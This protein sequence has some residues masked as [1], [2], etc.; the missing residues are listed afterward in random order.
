MTPPIQTNADPSSSR[1]CP[2]PKPSSLSLRTPGS[3]SV[4]QL[5]SRWETQPETSPSPPAPSA[6]APHIASLIRS[7]LS[8]QQNCSQP[9][10]V[11]CA[12]LPNPLDATNG[13]LGPLD[14]APKYG[15]PSARVRTSP[16]RLATKSLDTALQP[17]QQAPNP[18]SNRYQASPGTQTSPYSFNT[19][20]H[21]VPLRS[22]QPAQ[23]IPSPV[24][25]SYDSVRSFALDLPPPSPST[26]SPLTEH[27]QSTPQSTVD[28]I[29]S[30]TRILL[31]NATRSSTV[32]A[33]LQSAFA[34]PLNTLQSQPAS[35][36]SNNGRA[37]WLLSA[38]AQ[39]PTPSSTDRSASSEVSPRSSTP[40]SEPD[41][42]KFRHD[43]RPHLE[44]PLPKEGLSKSSSNGHIFDLDAKVHLG[45]GKYLPSSFRRNRP[46]QAA[47]IPERS[48]S[49]LLASSSNA[50]I[51]S[52]REAWSAE[53]PSSIPL[54]PTSPIKEMKARS[55]LVGAQA[56]MWTDM[57]KNEIIQNAVCSNVEG[58]MLPVSADDV[59]RRDAAPIHL[60]ALENYLKNSIMF[61]EPNFTDSRLVCTEQEKQLFD[62]DGHMMLGAPIDAAQT[63]QLP[64]SSAN[65]SQITK[66]RI[67][68]LRMSSHF[69]QLEV[70]GGQINC[71][72]LLYIS[73]INS[74][75][76]SEK[77]KSGLRRR[78]GVGPSNETADLPKRSHTK[79]SKGVMKVNSEDADPLLA[80]RL[81]DSS[82]KQL[83]ID[84]D[85]A[86]DAT[87]IDAKEE[88]GFNSDDDANL[89]RR[90]AVEAHKVASRISARLNDSKQAG[91]RSNLSEPPAEGASSKFSTHSNPV[92]RKE[93]FPP[94]MLLKE[95]NLDELKSNAI[96]P[97]KPPGGIWAFGWLGFIFDMVI[98]VEGSTFAAGILRLE[99]LRDLFQLMT[100][101][102]HFQQYFDSS[103]PTSTTS[104]VFKFLL[105]TLPAILGFDLVS[106]FGYAIIFFVIWIVITA[107]ALWHFRRMTKAHNPN[108]TVEGFDSQGWI[109]KSSS[110][111][112][113]FANTC[114]VFVL[115]LLYLPLSKLAVDVLVWSS[116]F[117]PVPD[118]YK[119]GIDDPIPGPLLGDPDIWRAPLD[120]CYTTT[121]RKDAFNWAY[122]II[123][124]AVLT[125][126]FY[127]LWYPYKLMMTIKEMLPRVSPFNELGRKRSEEEMQICYHRLLNRDKS[128]FNF[129][130]N[131]YHR[132]WGYYKPLYILLFKLTNLL[133]IGVLAKDNCFF[134]S[135]RTRTMLVVQ[136]STLIVVMSSLLAVHLT[137]QPFVDKN[138]NRSELVSRIGYV[139]TATIGLLVALNVQGSTVYN[140]TI[141]YIVQAFT[142][143]GNIYFG[144]IG[145]SF[146][147]HQIKR[148][149]KRVD[150]TIDIFSPVLDITKHIKRRVWEETFS[151]LILC[152]RE[153]H[154]PLEQVIAF[155]VSDGD[156]WPPYLIGFQGSVAER[157]IENLKIVKQIGIEAYRSEI[158]FS[159]TQ[160]GAYRQKLI[161]TIQRDLT[162]PDAY[163]RPQ[164]PP[165]PSGA[166][167]FFGKAFLVPFPPTLVIRYDEGTTNSITLTR[168]EEFEA[169]IQQNSEPKVVSQRMVRQAL[170]ALEGQT[171]FCPH[172][173][174][175]QVGD[176]TSGMA[177]VDKIFGRVSK[178]HDALPRFGVRT[179]AGRQSEY[180]L[181]TPISY[182]QGTLK[183]VRR[184]ELDW[185]GYNLDS[186]FEVSI[187][188]KEG[189]MKETT[190]ALTTVQKTVEVSAS[191]AFG[192]TDNFDMTSTLSRFLQD[193]ETLILERVPLIEKF[194][195]KYRRD[196]EREARHKERVLPYSFLSDV[197]DNDGL[198]PLG[199]RMALVEIG[200]G[201]S[202][203]NLPVLYEGCVTLMYERL[204]AIN[205]SPVHR[206]WWILFDEIWRLNSNDYAL[207][208]KYRRSFSPQYPTSIAYRP[209]PRKAL[210]E[211]LTERGLWKS[212]GAKGGP[213]NRGLLNRIYFYLNEIVFAGHHDGRVSD[214]GRAQPNKGRVSHPHDSTDPF[215]DPV[216][217]DLRQAATIKVGLGHDATQATR[218]DFS[219]VDDSMSKSHLF[220]PDNGTSGHREKRCWGMTASSSVTPSQ[221]T[222]GGTAYSNDSVI[223]RTAYRWEQ[224]MDG[225]ATDTS[226]QRFKVRSLQWLSLHPVEVNFKREK[227]YL[228]LKL[229]KDKNGQERYELLKPSC[230]LPVPGKQEI[231]E[232][233]ER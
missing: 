138:G 157:H 97:R 148:W 229:A 43:S 92:T 48:S 154:M 210:E 133:I 13:T 136:Q 203:R 15:M 225:F 117:W 40:R 185:A 110:R 31:E 35:H 156:E 25:P 106:V 213:F 232:R 220:L 82:E 182:V 63:P 202:L 187:V 102:L 112:T 100:L 19:K 36:Q 196:F 217:S 4:Q 34:S 155:S 230:S 231:G 30:K 7:P 149:Q 179:S 77:H 151:I 33:A 51:S 22:V 1:T 94:L 218:Q 90:D 86:D 121:M 153:Y 37:S 80:R 9:A 142:Y 222:G 18:F 228:Y 10:P 206:F 181:A 195:R 199:L 64:T 174:N 120:F 12:L 103:D 55:S 39:E 111:G 38:T 85:V 161:R 233:R 188:Y 45:T 71:P 165:F 128:P 171:V 124:M 186:G 215:L 200:C 72:A 127:T 204:A 172:V 101:Q 41:T 175:I 176:A 66:S 177:V 169:Y 224:M 122:I 44:P 214:A 226:W 69:G 114:L 68:K 26:F 209:I 223:V 164:E 129:L 135:F 65:R 116:D 150:Y 170:R 99:T 147:A 125:I 67:S 166:T 11:H 32:S 163:W 140:T 190:G 115:G 160:Q 192:L 73:S 59:F 2:E 62:L 61:G 29:A 159:R 198:S 56:I 5:V 119:G 143:G 6:S 145:M 123:P 137:I 227:L 132:S 27:T 98:G 58:D 70:A 81:I 221:Y 21:L 146:V 74:D 95:N 87:A 134:R 168:I 17:S 208:T 105:Q 3:P 183:I 54:L 96:G 207:L 189:K 42:D 178:R 79:K 52:A 158:D 144:L 173:E 201:R 197:F 60:P 75:H 24:S 167:S 83:S 216:D 23:T 118:P 53:D 131:S 84:D 93:M 76:N 50:D 219:T 211:F 57:V 191:R 141:L 28:T 139:L 47:P 205:R 180:V 91:A 46:E 184:N 88:R 78:R 8:S 14:W 108:K 113:R 194:L 16:L 130:Y 20:R 107:L 104:E 152:G 193:N 126:V 109:Y 49:H 162:G 212:N 89:I